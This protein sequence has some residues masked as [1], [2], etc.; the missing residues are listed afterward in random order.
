MSA[1][2]ELCAIVAGGR[3][4]RLGGRPKGLTLVDDRPNITRLAALLRPHCAETILIGDPHGPYAHLKIPTLPDDPPPRGTPGAVLTALRYATTRGHTW[5]WTL[6]CDLP[7]LDAPTLLA[8]IPHR[9]D[10]DAAIYRAATHLQPLAACWHARAL[11]TFEAAL[12]TASPGFAPIIH[13]L[14]AALIEAPDPTRFQD[15]DTP[16]DYQALGLRPPPG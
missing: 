10:H 6:A 4:H 15:L 14:D 3:A 8:L 13:A 5:I 2:T 16:A 11:P 7:H 1:V 9:L 12:A